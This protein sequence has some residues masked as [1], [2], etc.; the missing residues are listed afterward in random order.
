[1]FKNVLTF[2]KTFK[3]ICQLR[4]CE[5]DQH[6]TADIHFSQTI[7]DISRNINVTDSLT[8]GERCLTYIFR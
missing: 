2:E 8:D 6:S 5:T 4:R 7:F 3:T 1:M